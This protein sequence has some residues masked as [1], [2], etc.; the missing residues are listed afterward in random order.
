MST[1]P[2]KRD[3]FG[4]KVT[5]DTGSGSAYIYR[6]DRLA[7]SFPG[8]HRLPFS[9][10]VLLEAALRECDGF[11]VTKED[12]ERLASY[13]PKA[14]AQEEIPFMP[15]RVLLQDFTGVPAVVDLAAMRSAMARLGGDPNEI[16]PGVPVHLVIDHSVQVDAYGGKNAL[17][18]NA[19]F[20]FERNAERYEFLRWGQQAFDN[21]GVVPPASG[22]CHQVNLEYIARGVWSRPEGDGL[23]VAYPDSLVGTDSHTTMINGLGVV[24]WGVGGI[25]A[26]AVMLG[27]PIYMLIPQVVGFRLTGKLPEGATAT[28]LVLAVTQMLRAYG[29]VDKFVE[30]FGP[31][32]SRLTVPDRA[33]IANMAPEYGATMGFFPI[34]S[35]TIDFLRRTGRDESVVQLVERYT[36]EQGLFRTDATPDPEFIDI[37]TLD[38]ATVV[39]SLAGPKRPQ[40]RIPLPDVKK[41]FAT[42]LTTPPG[43]KGFGL[44]PEALAKKGKYQDDKGTTLDMAHGDVAIAAITSCTNTSNP[45]V[46]IGAGLVAKKA[47]ERGLTVKPFVKT[48]LAPGSKVVTDYLEASGLLPYLDQLGFNVVGYGCTTCI[49]NSGP[50]NEPVVKAIKEGNL[51]ASG[52]LSGNRNF[53]GRIHPN[54]QANFLASPPLVVAYALAGTVDIDLT[55]DAIGRDTAGK[56]VYLKEIWPTS[57]EIQEAVS[58]YLTPEMFTKE[59]TGIETSN[60]DWNRIKIPAGSIYE[61]NTESTYI[62]E[63]PYFEHLTRETPTIA[64]IHGA[65]V[66][67]I[68]GDSTTTDH[69]SPA[70]DIKGDGPAGKYLAERGVE[71]ADFNSFGSRRGNHQV[72]MRGTFANI[73]IKNKLL[74]GTEGGITKHFPTGETLSIYDASMRYQAAGT[75]LILFAGKDYGM[76]SSRDWAAKGTILLGV[77]AVIAESFERIHRSNLIGMGVLPLQF[78]N[79]ET[80]ASHG[81]DG[82]EIFDVPVTDE[83]K[84]RQDLVVTATKADGAK[85]SFK[86]TCRLDTPVEVDYYRNGGILHYVLRGFLNRATVGV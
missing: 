65:R 82:T 16:N 24:G 45:S 44:S 17:Q 7:K 71:R 26:E 73:R 1:T 75:P 48:S 2:N 31:G 50:L 72:M 36:K 76:G 54:V 10:K 5:F 19:G 4:A 13:N 68:W 11:L 40:D 57:K 49:G 69:I 85:V 46:M 83:V 27:Q 43:P 28:D 56:P 70:G 12:V 47:V 22:I 67:G 38:L 62:Q 20:E 81:L 42:S 52:V 6:L 41:V 25:E 35:E 30:F 59:Y 15:A 51:I 8:I 34:D 55:K 53:E 3:Y 84:P 80:Y 29:V 66:L 61:W 77:K 78:K 23:T 74:P 79:G 60:E 32:L 33:T 14:P 37:I 21:F 58:R 86:T 63:P 39:P 9:I 64:P 18:I